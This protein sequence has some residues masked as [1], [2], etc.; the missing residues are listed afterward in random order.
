MASDCEE[1]AAVLSTKMLRLMNEK[2]PLELREQIYRD[3][4]PEIRSTSKADRVP[5]LLDRPCF[6][7]GRGLPHNS[8]T[9]RLCTPSR[10]AKFR[11]SPFADATKNPNACEFIRAYL[12]DVTFYWNARAT[13]AGRMGH[14]PVGM[15][16]FLRDVRSLGHPD[17]FI[18]VVVAPFDKEVDAALQHLSWTIGVF[19]LNGMKAVLSYEHE[20]VSLADALLRSAELVA[21]SIPHHSRQHIRQLRKRFPGRRWAK[22]FIHES[23]WD[24][25]FRAPAWLDGDALP[26]QM[27][28]D[29][30]EVRRTFQ[31]SRERQP[32]SPRAWRTSRAFAGD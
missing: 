29:D 7:M 6:L 2:L 4:F 24:W 3:A 8:H 21:S 16:D 18:N 27:L 25:L 31:A 32:E 23:V 9:C 28:Q 1:S 30:A 10:W 14:F 19:Y 12:R 20:D 17:V 11:R 22:D 5:I 15:N 26:V 13:E